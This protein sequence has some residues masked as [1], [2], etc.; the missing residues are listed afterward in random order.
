[1]A[2]VGITKTITEDCTYKAITI[3]DEFLNDVDVG[4]TIGLRLKFSV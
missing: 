3:S 4:N 1:M 2:G